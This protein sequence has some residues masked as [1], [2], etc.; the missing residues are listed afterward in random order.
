MAKYA[1]KNLPHV[2]FVPNLNLQTIEVNIAA[3]AEENQD[4]DETL[5]LVFDPATNSYFDPESGKYYELNA[6]AEDSDS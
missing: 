4:E 6:D 2:S 1:N 5:E 3:A